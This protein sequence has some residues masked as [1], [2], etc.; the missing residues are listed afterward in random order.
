MFN[1]KVPMFPAAEQLAVVNNNSEW[2][3]MMKTSTDIQ[4][5]NLN[6]DIIKA[7]LKR[8]DYLAYIMLMG[9]IDNVIFP[10]TFK[11]RKR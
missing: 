9:Y 5:W 7:Y 10:I 1:S 11:L 8:V 2:I 6:R 4:Q 3:K